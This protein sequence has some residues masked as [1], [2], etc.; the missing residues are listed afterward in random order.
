MWNVR[1][2]E[3][4]LFVPENSF[5]SLVGSVFADTGFSTNFKIDSLAV[6]L[7]FLTSIMQL[8]LAIFGSFVEK[9]CAL[10]LASLQ[11][12]SW[13][14]RQFDI[15]NRP[16]KELYLALTRTGVSRNSNIDRYFGIGR[17]IDRYSGVE[18]PNFSV[19]QYSSEL[20]TSKWETFGRCT[21]I[22]GFLYLR[23]PT[24]FTNEPT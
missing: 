18:R 17:K 14:S 24:I 23:K 4:P 13:P 5:W 16:R 22:S 2:D 19:F 20:L 15:V 6:S 1:E 11:I 12:Y 21:G 7:E 10:S 9:Y 8:L 3:R